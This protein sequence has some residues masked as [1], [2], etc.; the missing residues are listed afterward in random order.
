MCCRITS[1][2]SSVISEQR[3]SRRCVS[4]KRWA[5]TV[6][7]LFVILWLSVAE[8]RTSRGNVLAMSTAVSEKS[9]RSRRS[10]CNSR[11]GKSHPIVRSSSFGHP[12]SERS[13][14]CSH[15]AT[16]MTVS[17]RTEQSSIF[18]ARRLRRSPSDASELRSEST[19]EDRVR[20]RSESRNES[21]KQLSG[22]MKQDD[23]SLHF[24]GMLESSASASTSLRTCSS[25]TILRHCSLLC[26]DAAMV[27]LESARR[28]K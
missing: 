17:V 4:R 5:I 15:F 20:E 3:A 26:V 7:P 9:P 18:N 1:S 16:G 2:A 12:E 21:Q 24:E 14:I 13:C 8:K 22:C 19:R 28:F 11:S 23:Q 10:V 27:L 25:P 6:T